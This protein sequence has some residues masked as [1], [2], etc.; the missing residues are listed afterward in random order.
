MGQADINDV[1][2]YIIIKSDEGGVGL[3]FLKLQK[4][5]YYTQA[6]HLA[7]G[8]GPLFDGKFQAWIHG[9]VSRSVYDR[10]KDTH[11]L[12]DR[13]SAKDASKNPN[14]WALSE[15]ARIHIDE[16]LEAYASLSGTQLESMTHNEQPW[17]VA[18]EGFRPSERCEREIDEDLMAH[19]YSDLLK[20]SESQDSPATR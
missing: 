9:P 5:L 10:F 17:I 14:I 6:W 2:D 1:V 3:N 12:Y 7:F 11:S 18:R 13:V 4:L 19:F 15:G 20:A 8:K 16:I